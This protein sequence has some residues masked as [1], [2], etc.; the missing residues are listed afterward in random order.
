M[1]QFKDKHENINM[2]L[3]QPFLYQAELTLLKTE[4]RRERLGRETQEEINIK[5]RSQEL[6][7][8]MMVTMNIEYGYRYYVKEVKVKE[9]LEN[10]EENWTTK[11]EITKV[12]NTIDK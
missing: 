5:N 8:F 11:K 12:L 2:K 3:L 9:E 6:A 10:G 1:E 7:V 4:G